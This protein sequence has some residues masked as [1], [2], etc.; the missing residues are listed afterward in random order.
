MKRVFD[1][2]QS[3]YNALLDPKERKDLISGSLKDYKKLLDLL[4]TSEEMKSAQEKTISEITQMYDISQAH[5]YDRLSRQK[6]KF[7]I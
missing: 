5:E 1:N 7:E 2:L 4:N 6:G 3:D